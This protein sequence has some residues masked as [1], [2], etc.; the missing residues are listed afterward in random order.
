MPI[1]V[2]DTLIDSVSAVD[3]LANDARVGL[4][5]RPKSLPPRWFYDRRGSELFEQITELEEYYP[6]RAERQ[7]LEAHA[8]ELAL[9]TPINTVVEL[10]SG[11]SAKTKLLL[12]AWQRVGSLRRIITL[13]VSVS[14]LTDAAAGLVERYPGVEVSPV[15]ADFTRHLEGL[16]TT[17]RTAVVFLGSTIGNLDTAQRAEFLAS[18]R[19]ALRPDGVLLLGTDLIKPVEVLI[20]AYDDAAGVT[21]AFNLNVL[22]VLNTELD[23]DLPIEAFTHVAVWNDER[24]RIEMRLRAGRTVD[25]ILRRIGMPVHFEAGEEMLTEISCK[26]CREGISAELAGAGLPLRQWWTDSEN[27]FAVS[28]SGQPV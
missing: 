23:G 3:E 27:R 21:A 25:A 24:H 4:A 20:P 9:Q 26:F 16:E 5:A 28:L 18:V 10:G 12:D 22:R 6:T 14:A 11:S 8:D 1:D 19:A 17:G 7:I 13:D 2:D 15:R